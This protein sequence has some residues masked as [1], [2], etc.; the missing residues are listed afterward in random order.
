MKDG[1]RAAFGQAGAKMQKPVGC[2]CK[3]SNVRKVELNLTMWSVVKMVERWARS[4]EPPQSMRIT[5]SP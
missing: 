5:K 3:D 4:S 1:E 2:K